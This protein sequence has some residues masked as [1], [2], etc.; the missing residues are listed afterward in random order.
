[1]TPDLSKVSD[2][3]LKAIVAGDMSSLSDAT[4]AMIAGSGKPPKKERSFTRKAFDVMGNI[5]SGA[6]MGATDIGATLMAPFDFAARQ[7]GYDIPFVPGRLGDR[8]QEITNFLTSQDADVN[9]LSYGGGRLFS[10]V[11]GTAGLG[12]VLG[13]GLK[14]VAPSAAPL[15]ASI[16]AGGFI[17]KSLTATERI[18]A[19][20]P[21]AT[22]LEK[23]T[24]LGNRAAG[25][26]VAGGAGAFAINPS[27]TGTGSVVGAL[28][29]TV[30][31][32]LV[33]ELAK[34]S[35]FL[36]DAIT[37]KLG[38]V[39]AAEIARQVAAGDVAA[40]RAA[41]AI[42]DPSLT[43]GQAAAG[44]DNTAW[45]ALDALAR[46]QNTGGAFTKKIDA[47]T[48]NTEATLDRLAGGPTALESNIAQK[49]TK[50]ALNTLTT[51][52][53]EAALERAGV[54]GEAV[55]FLQ[56]V[57][58]KGEAGATSAVADVRRFTGLI[59]PADNWA[60]TWAPSAMADVD[61]AGK[62]IR[63]GDVRLLG[64]PRQPQA[65]TYPGQLA[66]RAEGAAT[67]AAEESLKLG[68][69][70]RNAKTAI[71]DLEAQGL[72]PLKPDSIIASIKSKLTDPSIALNANL[73]PAL[74]RVTDMLGDWTNKFGVITPEALYAIRKNGIAGVIQDLH[75]TATPDQRRAFAQ[76]V[77]TE[78]RPLIDDA[79]EA[80]GGAGWKAYLK[81]FDQ[82]MQGVEQKRMADVARQLYKSGDKQGFIDLVKG[83]NDK[84][85][86]IVEDVFGPGKVNFVQ[87]MGGQR[88]NSPALEYMRIAEETAKNLKLAERA[89][90]GGAELAK[91]IDRNAL[92]FNFPPSLSTKIA[93]A[94]QGMKEFEG[95]INRSA[96]DALEK[97]MRSGASA[98][99]MLAMV[100]AAERGKVLKI[101]TDS[102]TWSPL[103]TTGARQGMV[104][105][106][107]PQE[108][109][110]RLAAP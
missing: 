66:V 18:A 102:A 30:G 37:G 93:V 84:A 24:T 79:I 56:Q 22:I 62:F 12:P 27:E 90:E 28:V 41:N 91:I 51:P 34:K 17:P 32:G 21:A 55:P 53:R 23:A 9:S 44:V 68:A 25:G 105:R 97:G 72:K 38:P 1:M 58:A 54:A 4:L 13:V 89:G 96:M 67:T 92:K 14:A 61:A 59:E 74:K 73:A 49:Q 6:L 60:R 63:G 20:L 57:A 31:A 95:K 69:I 8:R 26:A 46:K 19:G 99:E 70:A 107:A 85:L 33:S 29:P 108:N 109:R 42:A 77:M 47:Q 101:M 11:A 35:G 86:G 10:N 48:A 64:I 87:L 16:S 75:P 98:N 2:A 88:P 43:A 100:P 106:L 52:M 103:L 78:V 82:G 104:N 5:G 45:A 65:S 110:N 3:E 76:A 15:A 36:W 7:R 94:R 71:A 81:T 39:K 50:T 83:S 80:A 40:I